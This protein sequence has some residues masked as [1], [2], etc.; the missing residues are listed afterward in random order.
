MTYWWLIEVSIVCFHEFSE[1]PLLEILIYIHI[2][3]FRLMFCSILNNLHCDLPGCYLSSQGNQM[4]GVL[5]IPRALLGFPV[6]IMKCGETL[7]KLFQNKTILSIFAAFSSTF[8]VRAELHTNKYRIDGSKR[9]GF[10]KN[11]GNFDFW[12]KIMGHNSLYFR[13]I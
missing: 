7:Q 4:F 12:T 9:G 1:I 8:Q 3:K 6:S 11:W 5:C 2:C 10:I 13:D